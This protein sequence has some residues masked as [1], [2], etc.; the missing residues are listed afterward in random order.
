LISTKIGGK[1]WL[2]TIDEWQQVARA[3]TNECH[4]R[5]AYDTTW[6][7]AYCTN[8]QSDISKYE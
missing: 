8:L 3:D 5:V 6:P 2:T 4:R 7:N 1:E